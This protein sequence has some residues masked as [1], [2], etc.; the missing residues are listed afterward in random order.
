MKSV[1]PV[2]ALLRSGIYSK[3]YLNLYP[4]NEPFVNWKISALN[5]NGKNEAIVWKWID[6]HLF[7]PRNV[8]HWSILSN[9]LCYLFPFR[10]LNSNGWSE[11]WPLQRTHLLTKFY[12]VQKR[13]KEIN[14]YQMTTMS[15]SG[16]ISQKKPHKKLVTVVVSWEG[17]WVIRDWEWEGLFCTTFLCVHLKNFIMHLY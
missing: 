16:K 1:F 17:K 11:A 10:V 7:F 3:T 12:G 6:K 15:L 14:F 2:S 4:S 13:Q 8:L 9:F 5:S